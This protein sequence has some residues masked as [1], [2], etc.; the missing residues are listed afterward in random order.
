MTPDIRAKRESLVAETVEAFESLPANQ[1]YAFTTWGLR[2]S[3]S[4]VSRNRRE[5]T[6]EQSPV[7]LDEAGNPNANFKAF[8]GAI[9]R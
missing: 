5:G 4:F 7:F 9:R 1:R 2:D 8:I 6:P 3:D